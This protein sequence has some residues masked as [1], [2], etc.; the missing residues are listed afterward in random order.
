MSGLDSDLVL[1]NGRVRCRSVDRLGDVHLS[2]VKAS[3]AALLLVVD[4]EVVADDPVTHH[5][6]Y[7][8]MGEKRGHLLLVDPHV[9]DELVSDLPSGADAAR[10]WLDQ[11]LT[12]E[13]IAVRPV[14]LPWVAMAVLVSTGL[15]PPTAVDAVFAALNLV[16]TAHDE[17]AAQVFSE[18][19]LAYRAWHEARRLQYRGVLQ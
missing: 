2:G 8:V 5:I 14:S 12:V 15:A 9:D 1:L 7:S 3:G 6:F 4:R 13:V 11:R 18:K 17:V 10:W 19:L 16:P